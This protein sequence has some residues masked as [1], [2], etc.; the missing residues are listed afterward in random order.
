MSKNNESEKNQNAFGS[1]VDTNLPTEQ[2]R[3]TIKEILTLGQSF[4][5]VSPPLF[6]FV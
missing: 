4:L 6:L 2:E 5:I 1:K 3:N